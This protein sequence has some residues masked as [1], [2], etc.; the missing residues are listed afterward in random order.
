MLPPVG[1]VGIVNQTSTVVES[2]GIARI[3][4]AFL[5]PDEISPDIAV[6]ITFSTQD[7]A[8]IGEYY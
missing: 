3:Y 1:I 4:V 8:A 2:Q 7:N 5:E 6:N